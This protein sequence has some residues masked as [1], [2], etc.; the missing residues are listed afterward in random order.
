M[1]STKLEIPLKTAIVCS[2]C[3]TQL[4]AECRND[5]EYHTAV[6]VRPCRQC[7]PLER[8]ND[9]VNKMLLMSRSDL[10][11]NH[12]IQNCHD[13]NDF[14]CGDNRNK[15][16]RKAQRKQAGV[17]LGILMENLES[18]AQLVF[19]NDDESEP[20]PCAVCSRQ[21]NICIF[22]PESAT[23]CFGFRGHKS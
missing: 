5:L 18:A 9:Q 8:T 4:E 22:A 7:Q 11:R 15:M 21:R 23:E 17:I 3:G 16:I 20:G 6:I 14:D 19:P 2:Q 13:C 10:C 1:V 12:H